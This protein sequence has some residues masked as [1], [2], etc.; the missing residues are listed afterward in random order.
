MEVYLLNYELLTVE[1][2]ANILRL[3]VRTIWRM[4][5]DGRLKGIRLGG[6][7]RIPKEEL[8]KIL[9]ISSPE[10]TLDAF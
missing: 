8:E 2:V 7:W 4:L 3:N 1:E 9:V 5:K 10:G 6:G